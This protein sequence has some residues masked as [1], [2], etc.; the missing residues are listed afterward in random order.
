[1]PSARMAAATLAEVVAEDP[2]VQAELA[3]RARLLAALRQ[4]V[5][6]LTAPAVVIREVRP[7]AVQPRERPAQ[8]GISAGIWSA[9][10]EKRRSAWRRWA[11]QELSRRAS[12]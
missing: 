7:V 10:A 3:E 12:D 6:N 11:D 5:S 4:E 8:T 9:T 2:G 1:M